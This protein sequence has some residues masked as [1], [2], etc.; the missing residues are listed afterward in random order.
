MNVLTMTVDG[1]PVPQGSMKKSRHGTLIHSN[2]ALSSWRNAIAWVA[3][4]EWA[5]KPLIDEP[6]ALKV[7]FFLPKPKTPRNKRHPD[8][9]PDL[10]KLIR[11]V[12]DALTGVA[13]KDDSRIVIVHAQKSWSLKP[14]VSIELK[15]LREETR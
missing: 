4:T 7:E 6:C 8:T 2:E 11:A 10:D 15:S 9:K 12:G 5:G 14:G 13:L 1:I 3:K